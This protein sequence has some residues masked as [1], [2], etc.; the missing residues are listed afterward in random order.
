LAF[1]FA[2]ISGFSFSASSDRIAL[3]AERERI[4]AEEARKRT[5]GRPLKADKNSCPVI[6][7]KEA[8]QVK[9][10]NSTDYKIAKEIGISEDTYRNNLQNLGLKSDEPQIHPGTIFSPIRYLASS[11]CMDVFRQHANQGEPL[12]PRK[13]NLR[14]PGFLQNVPDMPCILG[15]YGPVYGSKGVTRGNNRPKV[16]TRKQ[17]QKRREDSTFSAHRVVV[18]IKNDRISQKTN[19][20]IL[21]ARASSTLTKQLYII[22]CAFYNS[23]KSLNAARSVD[24]IRVFMKLPKLPRIAIP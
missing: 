21:H 20:A 15:V 16:N 5:G 19:P 17:P 11:A 2:A 3:R 22:V 23:P 7:E 4:L 13:E 24:D 12:S 8:R 1:A 9:R 10:E 14:P 18:A 6:T